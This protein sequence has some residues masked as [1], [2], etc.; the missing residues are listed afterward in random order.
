MDPQVEAQLV[1]QA[2]QTSVLL[3]QGIHADKKSGADKKTI[4]KDFFAQW[5]VSFL[6]SIPAV[7]ANLIAGNSVQAAYNST[8]ADGTYDQATAAAKTPIVT[9]APV[10]PAQPATA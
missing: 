5:L 9:A 3:I 4:A 2:A 1:A 10:Q 6:P 8:K 7:L